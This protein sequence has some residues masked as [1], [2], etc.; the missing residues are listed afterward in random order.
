MLREMGSPLCNAAA[1]CAQVENAG[2]RN[3][4]FM[5]LVEAYLEQVQ[6]CYPLSRRRA[7]GVPWRV[8]GKGERRARGKEAGERERGGALQCSP[9][10]QIPY[11]TAG[12][13]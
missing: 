2:F 10:R 13:P 6:M 5:E 12:L 8:S 3:I 11:T 4:T 9:Y 7:K 1:A